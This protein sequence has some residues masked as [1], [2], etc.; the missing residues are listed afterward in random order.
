VG[1]IAVR[2]IA[3]VVVFVVSF[4]FMWW[5]RTASDPAL[6]E[7]A[8]SAPALQPPPPAVEH[9]APAPPMPAPAAP[10]APPPL[11]SAAASTTEELVPVDFNVYNR[12]RRN[13]IEGYVTNMTD[14]PLSVAVQGISASTQHLSSQ[15]Q[16]DLEPGEKK[17]FSTEDGLQLQA[18]DSVVLHS[19]PYQDRSMQVP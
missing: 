9:D 5:Q 8:S 17:N 14:K 2:A 1:K 15:I 4:A 10:A 7:A 16:L 19:P 13:V 11:A 12:R 18:N 3:L 6:P